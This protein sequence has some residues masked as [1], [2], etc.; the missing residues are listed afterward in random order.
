MSRLPEN[1]TDEQRLQA[2]R[3]CLKEQGFDISSL[4]NLSGNLASTDLHELPRDLAQTMFQS[5]ENGQGCAALLTQQQRDQIL[6]NKWVH[7]RDDGY[8]TKVDTR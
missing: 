8:E 1:A 2:Y 7:Q 6:Q 5:A 3:S 4:V